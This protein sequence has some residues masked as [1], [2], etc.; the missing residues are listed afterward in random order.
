MF[1]CWWCT[2]RIKNI[3]VSF[4]PSTYFVFISLDVFL[5]SFI[6]LLITSNAF[7]CCINP[8]HSWWFYCICVLIKVVW[9]MDKVPHLPLLLTCS[10]SMAFMWYW[11]NQRCGGG[12]ESSNTFMMWCTC[13]SIMEKQLMTSKSV[14]GLLWE[15]V[16]TNIGLVMHGQITFGFIT[17][18][19]VSDNIYH[20]LIFKII[21]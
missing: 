15:K 17:I 16:F 8:I 6:K 19:L 7:L 21:L 18:N 20:G 4:I 9:G 1:S 10:Q 13:P 5:V 11:K 12:V 3:T 2:S 14:G